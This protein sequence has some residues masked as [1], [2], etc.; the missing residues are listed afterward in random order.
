MPSLLTASAR[1]FTTREAPL[2]VPLYDQRFG[3]WQIAGDGSFVCGAARTADISIQQASIQQQ[4]CRFDYQDGRLTVVRLEGRVWVNEVPLHGDAVLEPDDVISLGSWTM[5]VLTSDPLRPAVSSDDGS[6][7]RA[8]LL[9]AAGPSVIFTGGT[10][11]RFRDAF[12]RVSGESPAVERQRGHSAADAVSDVTAARVSQLLE[13]E[14]EISRREQRLKAEE[15]RLAELLAELE[16]ARADLTHEQQQHE[17]A[18]QTMAEAV[19]IRVDAESMRQSLQRE[20]Q[21]LTELTEQLQQQRAQLTQALALQ[22]QVSLQA[23]QQVQQR[24]AELETQQAELNRQQLLIEQQQQNSLLTQKQ[25]Q[26]RQAELETRQAELN[27]QQL[28]IEQ[29][30]QNSLLAQQQVQQQQAELDTRQAELNRQQQLLADRHQSLQA[31]EASLDDRARRIQ[32]ASMARSTLDA[33]QLHQVTRQEARAAELAERELELAERVAAV[34]GWRRRQAAFL[35][36]KQAELDAV[37]HDL[38]QQKSALRLRSRELDAQEAAYSQKVAAASVESSEWQDRASELQ[39]ELREAQQQ[40]QLL[41]QQLTAALT[42]CEQL[43]NSSRSLQEFQSTVRERDILIQDLHQQLLTVLAERRDEQGSLNKIQPEPAEANQIWRH[44]DEASELFSPVTPSENAA[45]PASEVTTEASL[46]DSL[47]PEKQTETAEATLPSNES[48]LQSLPPGVL[49]QELLRL[50]QL[51]QP[52]PAK[53]PLNESPSANVAKNEDLTS[54]N[55]VPLLDEGTVRMLEQSD[56]EVRSHVERMLVEQRRTDDETKDMAAP[57][58]TTMSRR[59]QSR[60]TGRQE[61]GEAAPQPRPP[62]SYIEAYNN[63]SLSLTSDQ[64]AFETAAEA[65]DRMAEKAQPQETLAEEHPP[66]TSRT[67]DELVRYVRRTNT[68]ATINQSLQQ[69]RRLSAEA[70]QTAITKHALRRHRKGF[71]VRTTAI[72]AGMVA[73]VWGPPWLLLWTKN[74][75]LA[76]WGPLAVFAATCLELIRKLVVV[77]RLERKKLVEP[78]TKP[79]PAVLR[80]E[81]PPPGMDAEAEIEDQHPLL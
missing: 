11:R 70:S 22:Q 8:V 80:P 62:I 27:S 6:M 59:M 53:M 69:L 73:V 33:S 61:T 76:I 48:L 2:L 25:V 52:A 43:R 36:A 23:Q 47:A 19:A 18:A 32:Q 5:Q 51:S 75:Q 7:R 81:L 72:V 42:T 60:G 29:Q 66:V 55:I 46:T 68:N 3:P 58:P 26:Q 38:R 63:G 49:H 20:R 64:A 30:Q 44:P 35:T 16:Q 14:A 13:R 37:G 54:A 50:L 45:S 12:P 57:K 78:I 56:P 74:P 1:S 77:L 21:E 4:H 79:R 39:T 31:R 40:Q 34:C 9:G 65:A 24:Q 15:L 10:D 67:A 41:S 17:Q 28:M 71:L